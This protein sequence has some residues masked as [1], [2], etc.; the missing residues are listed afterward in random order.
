MDIIK[1]LEQVKLDKYIDENPE[2]TVIKQNHNFLKLMSFV[3]GYIFLLGISML[4]V[5]G[6]NDETPLYREVPVDFINGRPSGRTCRSMC[7]YSVVSV[8][9]QEKTRGGSS[10]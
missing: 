3:L 10:I 4:S 2:G 9:D 7:H 1:V 6:V 8:R 5:Y